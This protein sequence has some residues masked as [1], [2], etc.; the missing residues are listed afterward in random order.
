[1]MKS[2][3]TSAMGKTLMAGNNETAMS[4]ETISTSNTGR[5]ATSRPIGE[6]RSM[7]PHPRSTTT[8]SKMLL[9]MALPPRLNSIATPQITRPNI[10]V[11]RARGSASTIA[12]GTL[13]NWKPA[14]TNKMVLTSCLR[15]ALSRTARGALLDR[16]GSK[17]T[18]SHHC[19]TAI[20]FLSFCSESLLASGIN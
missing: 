9:T 3:L 6:V 1:M 18:R 20:P 13:T 2:I 10:I 14:T 5:F 16:S 19:R 4:S 15:R 17:L 7:R 12:P 8:I 11:P